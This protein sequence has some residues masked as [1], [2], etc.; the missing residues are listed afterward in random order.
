[1]P[2][3]WIVGEENCVRFHMIH[4]SGAQEIQEKGCH[5]R[6]YFV[7]FV[8]KEGVLVHLG[9]VVLGDAPGFTEMLQAPQEY[10]IHISSCEISH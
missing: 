6:R 10:L 2:P 5:K 4:D 3:S 7:R 8:K 9:N 1:M